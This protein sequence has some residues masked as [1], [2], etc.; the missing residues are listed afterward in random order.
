[1]WQ[2]TEQ[3]TL[4]QSGPAPQTLRP[5]GEIR[6]KRL[7]YTTLNYRLSNA[8]DTIRMV[9]SNKDGIPFRELR[10]SLDP[11]A[12][13]K[14][15]AY[16]HTAVLP[17]PVEA[18]LRIKPTVALRRQVAVVQLTD[19]APRTQGYVRQITDTLLK[20]AALPFCDSFYKKQLLPPQTPGYLT[21]WGY[22]DP[23]CYVEGRLVIRDHPVQVRQLLPAGPHRLPRLGKSRSIPYS[24]F[25][26]GDT[27]T[28]TATVKGEKPLKEIF[29]TGPSGERISGTV[30]ALSY[31]DTLVVAQE[32]SFT[33][34]L[35]GRAALGQQFVEV[36]VQRIRPM[37]SDSFYQLTDSVFTTTDTLVFD[38][39]LVTAID[40]SLL[41]A[42]IWNIEQSPFGCL[43]VQVP[44]QPAAGLNLRQVAYWIGTGR[45][46]LNAYLELEPTV[47]PEWSLPGAP[48]AL[49]ALGFG[50]PIVL[51][52]IS[53][54]DV[55][56]SFSKTA[57]AGPGKKSIAP[58]AQLPEQ[59]NA[60]I[61]SREILDDWS[62]DGVIEA[63]KLQSRT[64]YACFQNISTVNTY[65][66][67]IKVVGYYFK[68]K[69]TKVGVQLKSSN[70]YTIPFTRK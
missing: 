30:N 45:D 2:H 60:G 42:P 49:G 11:S 20:P 61:L 1:M 7:G 70:T 52:F 66:V 47:P 32:T 10:W 35:D 36:A 55:I 18:Q 62:S 17:A 63:S 12:Q 57:R 59:K 54:Q 44:T 14:T 31:A 58:L 26:P 25:S 65:P 50:R 33:L 29:L 23:L 6:L 8:D 9:V 68:L 34:H 39:L 69:D 21:G 22:S 67:A 19:A 40:D 28:F 13:K 15:A 37:A 5:T 38:T 43:K 48:P 16:Q 41:L 53:T 27:L 4:V 64:F 3:Q 46:A 56:C 51:P 24:D